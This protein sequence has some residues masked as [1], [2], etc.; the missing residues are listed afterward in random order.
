MGIVRHSANALS[1]GLY[2]RDK[3]ASSPRTS[4]SLPCCVARKA[5]IRLRNTAFHHSDFPLIRK[6]PLFFC[7]SSVILPV[8]NFT[9]H[10]TP[11]SSKCRV[12]EVQRFV[13]LPN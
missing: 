6:S 2:Q 12:K 5:S 8:T 11:V 13:A 7:S 9:V 10:D 1:N 4:L 3:C